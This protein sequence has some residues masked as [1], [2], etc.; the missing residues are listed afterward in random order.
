MSRVILD[1]E[2]IL[3]FFFFLTAKDSIGCRIQ[4]QLPRK[5]FGMCTNSDLIFLWTCPREIVGEQIMSTMKLPSFICTPI[6]HMPETLGEL[7]LMVL[8]SWLLFLLWACRNVIWFLFKNPHASLDG[9]YVSLH[10]GRPFDIVIVVSPLTNLT[11][12]LTYVLQHI[13]ALNRSRHNL[14]IILE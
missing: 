11:K 13:I 9:N 3:F 8:A 7:R 14:S 10:S 5:Q 6:T 4:A 2:G 1:R 12:Q